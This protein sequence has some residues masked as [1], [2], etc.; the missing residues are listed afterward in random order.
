MVVG[1]GPSSMAPPPEMPY[2]PF[3]ENSYKN[4]YQ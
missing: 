1:R 3:M 4:N 2:S